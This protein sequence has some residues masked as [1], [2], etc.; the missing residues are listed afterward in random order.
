MSEFKD[1]LKSISFS[2][3]NRG[4]SIKKPVQNEETG[5]TA[6]YHTEHWDD[7]QDATVLAP[8]VELKGKAY[9]GDNER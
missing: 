4:R 8:H 7:R 9:G 2:K 1:K 3:G 6:G 5:R